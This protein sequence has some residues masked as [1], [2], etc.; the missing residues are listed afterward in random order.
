MLGPPCVKNPLQTCA[1]Y[2][3]PEV[4][5]QGHNQNYRSVSPATHLPST[6]TLRWSVGQPVVNLAWYSWSDGKQIASQY[7]GINPSAI[8]REAPPAAAAAVATETL[9]P[10]GRAGN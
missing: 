7:A 9:A 10:P 8:A 2:T 3:G 1:A 4:F 5:H 6:L